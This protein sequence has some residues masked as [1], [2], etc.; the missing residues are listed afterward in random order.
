MNESLIP[1]GAGDPE[2]AHLLDLLAH[3]E[4]MAELGRLAAG[5]V[6]ELNTPLSVVIS[7]T[8]LILREEELSEFVRE[9]VERINLEA[10][11]LSV[12]AKGVLSF[13]RD[14][15]Q[16]SETDVNAVL[17]DV[18]GFLRYEAQKRSIKIVEDLDFH[19]APIS[20]SGNRLKQILINIIMNALHAMRDGGTL[21]LRTLAGEGVVEIQIG[22][23]GSGI[24]DEIMTR[25]FE[26]FFTT[27]EVGEGT[28]LGLYVTRKLVE[29]FSGT[30]GVNST[31]GEG[32]TFF[33]K[34]P[35]GK[36]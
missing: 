17:T 13:A 28:G 36:P 14:D 30:I 8:Q 29:H 3:N 4:K 16:L 12:Y 31:V 27:K 7:A 33:L 26:P 20:V 15:E 19:L 6:H 32:T 34:F 10:Q 18:V 23:T 2:D 25:I 11:R 22:D 5:M 21:T 9:M 35:P 1:N 24:P